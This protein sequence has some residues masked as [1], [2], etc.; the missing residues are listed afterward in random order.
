MQ[1]CCMAQYTGVCVWWTIFTHVIKKFLDV[2]GQ[3]R[4]SLYFCLCAQ[5]KQSRCVIDV[6]TL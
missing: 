2:F 3:R 6:Q 5:I 4:I 1:M